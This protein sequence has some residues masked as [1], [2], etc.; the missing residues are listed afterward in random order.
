MVPLPLASCSHW[1]TPGVGPPPQGKG[2]LIFTF[3]PPL[4][5]NRKVVH[6]RKAEAQFAENL[7]R[8]RAHEYVCNAPARAGRLNMIRRHLG[9]GLALSVIS[10]MASFSST[11]FAKGTPRQRR[12]PR[13]RPNTTAANTSGK[14][15]R[16]TA[17]AF[18]RQTL[19]SFPA[20]AAGA[21]RTLS[22]ARCR[23]ARSSRPGGRRL[24]SRSTSTTTSGCRTSTARKCRSTK[25][26]RRYGVTHSVVSAGDNSFSIKVIYPNV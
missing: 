14:T 16:S 15:T 10:A 11:A 25:T 18:T 3:A 7:G 22:A 8:Q 6:E 13:S 4:G 2:P 12:A 9:V 5:T 23:R 20:A 17:R 26:F 21:A 1:R 19:S 24:V